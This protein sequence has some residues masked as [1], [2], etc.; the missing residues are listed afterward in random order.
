MTSPSASLRP[1]TGASGASVDE[2]SL[3]DPAL[4]ASV[5]QLRGFF[6]GYASEALE[7]LI[8]QSRR[9]VREAGIAYGIGL[10]DD[11]HQ[12]EAAFPIDLVPLPV[13][14]KEWKHI[15]AGITQRVRG[16]NAFLKDIYAGQE[17]LRAGVVPFDVVYA[18][19]HFHRECVGIPM[20]ADVF[21]HVA[22]LDLLRGPDGQ[23]CVMEDNMSN[24]SGASYALQN[25]RVL[26]Q[27]C[28]QIFQNQ[29][30][31][32]VFDY[33]SRLLE[34]L[35][36]AAP[37]STAS[38][39]VVSLSP[40]LEHS[41]Y[42]DHGAMARQMGIPLVQSSDLIVLDSE[43]YLKTIGGLERIDVLYRR[44]DGNRL[45]PVAFGQQSEQG[46]PGLVSCLRKGT[47]TVANAL[48][49]GLGDNRALAAYL[50]AILEFYFNEKPILNALPCHHLADVDQ[51]E[52]VFEQ[53][54]QYAFKRV[55]FRGR[56]SVWLGETMDESGWLALRERIENQP[57]D[58]VAQ[59]R[60]NFSTAPTCVGGKLEPRHVS[61]RTF[62][63]N[64]GVPRAQPVVLS[65]VSP[66]ED[67]LLVSSTS[68][69]GSKDTWVLRDQH[70]EKE[71][72][73]RPS[74][75]LP[76]QAP[77]RMHLASRT[78]EAIYWTA[79]YAER[80]EATVRILR[81]VQQLSLEAA[82]P[83]NEPA[84]AP[85]WEALASA[86]GH[87]TQFF[88]RQSFQEQ[89]G[90]GLA[91]Y[92]LLEDASESSAI[93][94]LRQCRRNAMLVREALPPEVWAVINRLYL[95]LALCAEQ[96]SEPSVHGHLQDLTLHDELLN[97]LDELSGA[98]QKHMLHNDAWHF[99]RI[100]RY[101]ESA[102]F[103]L[104]TTRQVFIKRTDEQVAHFLPQDGNLDALLRMMAGQYAYRSTYR[105]RP[106]A[107]AVALLLLRDE[108]FP[109][110]VAYCLGQ[111]DEAFREMF[112]Q[113]P[114]ALAEVP[115]RYAGQ[116]LSELRYADLE[117]YFS[118]MDP[119]SGNAATTGETPKRRAP[120]TTR[121]RS[122]AD[123]L[124]RIA[125]K[126]GRL[127]TRLSDHF[128]EHQGDV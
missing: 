4:Q 79:R 99:W 68:G 89:R 33:P 124:N 115:M 38:A 31:R 106:L 41:T 87:P 78:A 55:A 109:R 10:D 11:L 14:P 60:L 88:K 102:F 118:Q 40:G 97:Q 126:L 53:W 105:S 2:W 73:P 120:R 92:I 21:V 110:S 30:V 83:K 122:L 7:G 26:S 32:S 59:P 96:Q 48:G 20:P 81:V 57:A 12:S 85:L 121:M 94:S 24:S 127:N 50:P 76:H 13:S 95:H 84:W 1:R 77:R 45:D 61:L 19:P 103:T 29:P 108:E 86:T 52:A 117:R 91:R 72:A 113:R 67:S 112:G 71:A 119:A 3:E 44:T 36:A 80:V 65:R 25:R 37:T 28:P 51:R 6:S 5:N 47:L 43:L 111:V 128:F 58:F 9:Q 39:R 42:F 23:W 101:T 75:S 16:W 100:G 8:R 54:P 15:A 63:L 35:Q 70:Q 66:R 74:V 49:S 64:D 18:D 104:L 56:D 82:T 69:G 107:S 90:M 116:L 22:A 62:V 46:I 98:V 17:I 125:G 123:W 34:T 93:S 27:V 114:P